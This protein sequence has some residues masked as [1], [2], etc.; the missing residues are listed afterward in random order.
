[1]AEQR[2]RP[3]FQEAPRQMV[4]VLFVDE[5]GGGFDALW[6]WNGSGEAG[7]LVVSWVPPTS[8]EPRAA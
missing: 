7:A 2:L 6:V 8:R 5:L 1:M 4:Y 3:D